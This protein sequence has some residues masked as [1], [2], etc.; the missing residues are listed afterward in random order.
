MTTKEVAQVCGVTS[1]CIRQNAKKVG[2]DVGD[3]WNPHDW[4]EDELKKIQIQLMANSNNQG[5]G[6]EM[7]KE[8]TKAAFGDGLVFNVLATTGNIEAAQEYCDVL[9]QKVKAQHDLLLEQQKNQLLIEQKEILQKEV[10]KY[11]N[12]KSAKEI[13]LEYKLPTRPGI[14]KVAMLLN[15][16]ENED[17]IA[18]FYDDT[19]LYK[20]I[21]YKPEAVERIV[22]Y[23]KDLS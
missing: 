18:R 5:N 15:L 4:T 2:I 13:K 21:L 10:D 14:E 9:M 7:I 20:K 17:W 19:H 3:R 8:S 11:V 16:K 23:I 22:E 12:W 1:D 6:N